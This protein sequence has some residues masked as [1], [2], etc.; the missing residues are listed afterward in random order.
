[1]NK[2]KYLSAILTVV[3]LIAPAVAQEQDSYEWK[4]GKWTKAAPPAKGTPEGELSLIRKLMRDGKNRK[5]VKAAK[6]FLDRYPASKLLED[7]SYLAGNAEFA[8]NRY[9]QAFEWYETQLDYSPR[10]RYYKLAVRK[11]YEIAEKFLAGEKRVVLGAMKLS[12]KS[13]ALEI[14][15]RVAEHVPGTPL[16]QKA[17]M[18]VADWK[19]DNEKWLEAAD[20]YNV[21]VELFPKSRKAAYAALH[22]AK[23]MYF[24]FRGTSFDDTPLLEAQQRFRNFA[25][26]YPDQAVKA[27]VPETLRQIAEVR[28]EKL[29]ATGRFYERTEKSSAA[30]YYYKM[31]VKDFPQSQSAN[32]ARTHLAELGHI[33]A[34]K[35]AATPT[36]TPAD[37]NK[38][39]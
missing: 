39:G 16:A 17:L 23:A 27:R 15:T 18:L 21:F 35:P 10:G 6:K 30:V 4:G 33:K 13:E 7:V 20:A 19:F 5:A 34:A 1:M 25:A 38:A 29:L 11:E 14:L 26:S 3:V 32:R 2:A 31:L 28:A 9:F 8:R 22:S 37:K 12:A 24:S 36:A